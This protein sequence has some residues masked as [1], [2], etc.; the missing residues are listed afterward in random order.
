MIAR[1][2]SLKAHPSVFRHLTGLT[3][4][5]FDAPAADVVPAVEVA[6]RRSLDRPD[7]ERAVGAGGEWA[8]LGTWPTW[9][10]PACTRGGRVRPP[11]GSPGVRTARPRAGSTTGRSA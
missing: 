5:A 8:G 7:R 9:G 4:P 3:V 10:S 11:G 1:L 2:D 6:H